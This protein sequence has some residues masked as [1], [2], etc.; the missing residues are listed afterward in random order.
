MPLWYFSQI[1]QY[2][3]LVS[4]IKCTRLD[5]KTYHNQALAY[6]V[7]SHSLPCTLRSNHNQSPLSLHCSCFVLASACDG[8]V[9]CI[10]APHHFNLT[11][12][13]L[14][15]R[16]SHFWFFYST[17]R[18]FGY[19]HQSIPYQSIYNLYFH[20]CLKVCFSVRLKVQEK[21][22]LILITSIIPK[23]EYRFNK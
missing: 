18:S 13:I 11:I 3:P 22:C 8:H 9:M 23:T 1:L 19:Q 14:F 17:R 10:S 7:S 20:C 2:F 16:K 12:N 4:R 6:V 21:H 5:Y 15:P